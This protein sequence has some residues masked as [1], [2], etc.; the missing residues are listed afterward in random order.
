M[1]TETETVKEEAPGT[2]GQLL[3]EKRESLGLSIE[4]VANRLRLRVAIINAI[5]ADNFDIDKVTTFTKGYVRSYAKLVGIEESII[6]AA[7]NRCTGADDRKEVESVEMKSF[8]RQTS[9]KQHNNRINLI[10]FC[11]VIIV[12]GI[13]SVWWYQNQQQDSLRPSSAA[14]AQEEQEGDNVAPTEDISTDEATAEDVDAQKK[15]E[16]EIAPEEPAAD[17]SVNSG[18]AESASETTDTGSVSDETSDVSDDSNVSEPTD[19]VVTTTAST[20][21]LVMNFTKDCWISVKDSSGKTLSIGLKKA[22][23]HLNLEGEKPFSVVLGAPESVSMTFAGEPV[24]LS[25]YTSGKVAR[26]TLP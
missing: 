26:F 17:D 24:D 19:A 11:I 2:P 20:P 15:I 14:Q 6:L 10:T 12:V 4:Q 16:E 7:F 9:K 21:E 18:S 22:G 5:E 25:G 1:N 23:S 3:R 13:S 8:S